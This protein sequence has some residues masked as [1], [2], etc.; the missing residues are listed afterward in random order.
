MP[1][2][3]DL[4]ANSNPQLEQP[5]QISSM[6][7]LPL[8]CLILILFL[9]GTR[10]AFAAMRLEL[11]PA[12]VERQ[13]TRERNGK[14]RSEGE[15]GRVYSLGLS[16]PLADKIALHLQIGLSQDNLNERL[17]LKNRRVGL[18]GR[19]RVLSFSS[20]E[21]LWAAAG[22]THHRFGRSGNDLEA[23]GALLG[24]GLQRELPQGFGFGLFLQ[25]DQSLFVQAYRVEGQRV[26]SRYSSLVYGAHL[27]CAL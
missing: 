23:Y 21:F 4:S 12:A 3:R 16:R 8:F 1:A 9:T 15:K 13:W 26:A 20:S 18:E 27:S 24:L 5:M 2:S 14:S 11:S 22:L 7:P 10:P 17:S 19:Y 25:A 6:L